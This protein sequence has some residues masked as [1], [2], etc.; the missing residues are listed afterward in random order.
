MISVAHAH[1]KDTLLLDEKEQPSWRLLPVPHVTSSTLKIIETKDQ[2]SFQYS[3]EDNR[4][5][6]MEETARGVWLNPEDSEEETC[7]CACASLG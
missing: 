7:A 2:P 1:P 3:S 6:E 4:S 5:R